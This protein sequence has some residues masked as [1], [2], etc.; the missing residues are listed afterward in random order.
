MPSLSDS[1]AANPSQPVASPQGNKS[2]ET[3]ALETRLKKEIMAK[4][5][6]TIQSVTCP[7]TISPTA[8]RGF[9]CQAIAE[10]K[11]FTVAITPKPNK[12]STTPP[13]KPAD[14]K[15]ADPKARE[16]KAS[17]PKASD[18]KPAKNELQWNTKGL[19]VLP[20]LERTIQQG[21]KQQFQI[22]V[23]T[24]CGG[25]VRIAKPGDTFECKVTDQ[26]GQTK[27]VQVRVDNEQGGVTWKL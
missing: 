2:A 21:I 6:I 14:P 27:A 4:S 20:K 23:K 22:D 17:D 11:S 9:E 19:L 3:Q 10:N 26:R 24:S 8:T 13:P 1:P 5:G 25:K 12:T 15:P 18:P 7:A 16:P